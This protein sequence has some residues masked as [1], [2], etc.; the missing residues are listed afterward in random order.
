VQRRR[1]R[2]ARWTQRAQVFMHKHLLERI[3]DSPKPIAPPLPLE[4]AEKFPKLRR[5]AARMVGIGVQPEHIR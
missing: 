3:F 2:A 4:L 1:Q 5:I